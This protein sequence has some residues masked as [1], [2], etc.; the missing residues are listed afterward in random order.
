MDQKF[1]LDDLKEWQPDVW[2]SFQYILNYKE[3]APL[4]DILARTF[5]IDY[6]IF[7]EKITEN[8]KKDGDKIYVTKENRQEFIDLYIEHL[9][10]I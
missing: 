10:L 1:D 6:E 2:N 8:L 7:G 9:F 5:T 4:E 3:E